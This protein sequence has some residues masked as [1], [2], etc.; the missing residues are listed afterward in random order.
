MALCLLSS[1]DSGLEIVDVRIVQLPSKLQY[2]S[3]DSV[4]DLN[5]GQIISE[6]KEGTQVIE[7]MEDLVAE[8]YFLVESDIDFHIPGTYTVTLKNDKFSISYE[9]EVV[10]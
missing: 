10:S 2:T 8:K 4:I 5:G 1:C 7:A 3:D 6:L 9:V